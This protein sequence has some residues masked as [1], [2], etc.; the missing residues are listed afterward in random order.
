MK[1]YSGCVYIGFNFY[2]AKHSPSAASMIVE[3]TNTAEGQLSSLETLTERGE[4]E[5]ER[6]DIHLEVK[7]RMGR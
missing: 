5:K 4:K 3:T 6:V 2:L 1:T 7:V